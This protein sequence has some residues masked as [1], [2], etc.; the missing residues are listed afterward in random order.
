MNNLLVKEPGEKQPQQV[1]CDGANHR[2]ARKV[3]AIEVIDA[4]NARIRGKQL[5]G[6]LGDRYVHERKYSVPECVAEGKI[7]AL[8]DIEKR[9]LVRRLP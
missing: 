6:K 3:L 8:A 2:F 7:H 9:A 5:V 4:A 1:H